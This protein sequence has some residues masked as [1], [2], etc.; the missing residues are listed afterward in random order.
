MSYQGDINLGDTLEFTFTTRQSTGAPFALAG[1]PSMAAYQSGSNTPITSGITLTTNY[2]GVT[3]LN[4]VSVVASG[5]NGFSAGKDVSVV[6]AAG[7]VNGISVV[8]ETVGSFSI[9]NRS[10]VDAN[11][12]HVI[13]AAIQENGDNTTNWGGPP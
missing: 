8:G 10:T 4:N 3:G 2:G 12:T 1:S 7:T 9:Q 5:G 11:I 13:G 6:I